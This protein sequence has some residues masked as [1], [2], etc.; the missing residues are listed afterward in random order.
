[1]RYIILVIIF[2]VALMVFLE[3]KQRREISE[4]HKRT[5]KILK[6]SKN[7]LKSLNDGTKKSANEIKND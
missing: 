7:I 3:I 4:S 6:D 5:D 2:I 1:M